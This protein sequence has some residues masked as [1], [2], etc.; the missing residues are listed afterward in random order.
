M[1]RAAA[2]PLVEHA[3][4]LVAD[5]ARGGQDASTWDS[6]TDPNYNTVRDQVLVP[7]GVTEAQVQAIWLKVANA[8]PTVPLPS[9]TADAFTLKAQSGNIVRACR[10]RYPNLQIVFVSTRIY[11]GYASSVLNPEPYAYESAFGAKWLIQAQIAQAAGS[12]IDP[13]AG[14]LAYASTP[15]ITWGPYLW[16]DGLTP[17]ADALTWTCADFVSDGTHPATSGRTKVA[18]MLMNYS[19][20]SP[21]SAP[22]LRADH[23]TPCR[24]DFNFDGSVTIQD[25]FDF[26]NAYFTGVIP[27]ADFNRSGMATTQ[28][29]FDFLAAYFVGCA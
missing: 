15:W 1:G 12:G 19:L 5:G 23:T 26:L 3:R 18:D 22:W 13:Q 16:A 24:V 28:D 27:A 11:A 2:S 6:V 7:Q 20:N 17:R 9:P 21:F 14:D 29:I 25:L 8:Q 4:L 10:A